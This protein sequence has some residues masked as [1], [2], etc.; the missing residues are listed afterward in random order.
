MTTINIGQIEA[1]DKQHIIQRL[2]EINH[3]ILSREDFLEN[4]EF[5]NITNIN[6][7]V[8]AG[9]NIYD[10]NPARNIPKI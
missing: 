7:T 6:A 5:E 1:N 9:I 3:P 10:Q 2:R 8:H 4:I